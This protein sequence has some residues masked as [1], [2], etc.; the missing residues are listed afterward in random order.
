MHYAAQEAIRRALCRGFGA[1]FPGTT[2]EVPTSAAVVLLT[3]TKDTHRIREQIFKGS[4]DENCGCVSVCV[5][6]RCDSV[7]YLF[8][9]WDTRDSLRVMSLNVTHGH[10]DDRAM[11][12]MVLNEMILNEMICVPHRVRHKCLTHCVESD[13]SS[14]IPTPHLNPNTETLTPKPA[15][16]ANHMC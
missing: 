5:C 6:A 13:D 15:S 4:A 10:T 1:V 9:Q 16:H 7:G 12:R 14:Y 2:L 11:R 3:H 8:I